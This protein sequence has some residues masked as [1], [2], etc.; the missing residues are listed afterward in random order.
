MWYV[1]CYFSDKWN[2]LGKMAK[3]WQG[4]NINLSVLL[5]LYGIFY[6]FGSLP[7]D[8]ASEEKGKKMCS[9]KTSIFFTMI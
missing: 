9:N 3:T 2:T 1:I 5:I 4:G 8:L 6:V 7:V